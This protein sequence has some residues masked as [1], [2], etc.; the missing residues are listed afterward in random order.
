MDVFRLKVTIP[1][2]KGLYRLIEVSG[3]CTFDDLHEMIYEA[4]DRDDPHLYSFYITGKDTR[5]LRQIRNAPEI[6]HPSCVEPPFGFPRRPCRSTSTTRLGD[7][8]LKEKDVFFYL[9]DFGDEWWHRIR[10]EAVGETDQR[11][12]ILRVVK[13][14]GASPPQY[15]PFEE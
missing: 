7:V 8:G 4:F 10:V 5:S 1:G 2:L 15:P 11:K 3:N 9:F 14:A 6:T 12:K 13:A